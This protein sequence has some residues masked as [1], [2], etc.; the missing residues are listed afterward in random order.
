MLKEIMSDFN[1]LNRHPVSFIALYLDEITIGKLCTRK[2]EFKNCTLI[3]L[4][5]PDRTVGGHTVGAI[6]DVVF[7]VPL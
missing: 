6:S 5:D 7:I 2:V 1:F 3:T 4:F